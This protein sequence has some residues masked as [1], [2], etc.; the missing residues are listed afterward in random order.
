MNKPIP[1]AAHIIAMTRQG[2]SQRKIAE[3]I[4][5]DRSTV[6]QRQKRLGVAPTGAA[7]NPKR[8]IEWTAAVDK[9]W[10]GNLSMQG[11]AKALGVARS[12]L[13]KAA[14]RK[15]YKQGD[16]KW[17]DPLAGLTPEQREDV[18]AYRRARYTIPEAIAAATAASAPKV[19]IRSATQQQEARA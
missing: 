9:L 3:S 11:V 17:V 4:G 7:F 8:K 15:G 1:D 6:S 10:H 2:A 12:T 13:A 5:V 14:A 16:R 19:K 18:S